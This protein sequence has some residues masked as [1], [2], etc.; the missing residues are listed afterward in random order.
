MTEEKS[1]KIDNVKL[2]KAPMCNGDW[3]FYIS[4]T[5]YR[6]QCQLEQRETS[7]I[8]HKTL[9]RVTHMRIV[10]EGGRSGRTT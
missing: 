4:F 3:L 2:S 7:P 9:V 5:Q 6:T 8:V 1:G 10:F